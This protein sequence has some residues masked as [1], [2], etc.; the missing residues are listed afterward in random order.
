[1]FLPG[2]SHGQRSLAGYSPWGCKE[3]DMTERLTQTHTLYSKSKPNM[4]HV[5]KVKVLAGLCSFLEAGKLFSLLPKL[6]TFLGSWL[7]PPPSKPAWQCWPV[8]RSTGSE[9]I[10]LETLIPLYHVTRGIQILG[11]KMC[12]SLGA[13]ALICVAYLI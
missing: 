10:P 2:E 7:L 3:L 11:V 13:V 12:M 4:V 5:A 1:M 8:S 6:P 9:T